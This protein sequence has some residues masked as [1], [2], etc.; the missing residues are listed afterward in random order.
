[1]AITMIRIVLVFD[2]V[3]TEIPAI[4]NFESL[5]FLTHVLLLFLAS[6]ISLCA[7]HRF[8]RRCP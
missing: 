8:E 6:C 4:L 1:M 2:M 5:F 7:Q 3:R